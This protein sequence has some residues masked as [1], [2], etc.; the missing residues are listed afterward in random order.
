MII[1]SMQVDF[2][3]ID[4]CNLGC[5][6][7]S[8]FS[9][10]ADRAKPIPTSV[11][12]KSLVLLKDSCGDIVS[13]IFIMGGEPMLH[14]DLPEI[15][16]MT[17]DLF[18][19]VERFVVSNMLMYRDIKE[20]L[21]PVLVETGTIL[22]VSCY[23]NVNRRMI[24]EAEEDRKSRRLMVSVFGS[25][26]ANFWSYPK[27]D[28]PVYPEDG[29]YKCPMK[30]CVTLRGNRLYKCSPVAYLQYPRVKFGIDVKA[31][32]DDWIDLRTVKSPDEVLEGISAPHTFCRHCDMESNRRIG[33]ERSRC[34]I[35]EWFTRSTL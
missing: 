35:G 19:R 31:S 8:H 20:E 7:C 29:F 33:W 30:T 5:K 13:T 18:P 25:M 14:P 17:N 22:G 4:S 27:S 21:V 26:P 2:P 15:V 9:P 28:G 6:S 12:K 16:R 11:L 1:S 10:L 34:E 23:G 24:A 32:P 3:I